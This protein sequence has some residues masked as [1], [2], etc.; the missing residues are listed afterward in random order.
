MKKV[1]DETEEIAYAYLSDFGFDHAEI[2]PLILRGKQDLEV[3]L[4]K[5]QDAFSQEN[6]SLD[7]IGDILHALK[8]LFYQ[9]GN[10]QLAEKLNDSKEELVNAE[11]LSEIKSLL[12]V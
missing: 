11:I 7:Y 4:Q 12:L 10:H 5:L 2:Q 8:G 9:L 1:I 6:L 3:N